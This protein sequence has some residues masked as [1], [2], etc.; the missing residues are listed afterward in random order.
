MHS[1]HCAVHMFDVDWKVARD[2]T[3]NVFPQKF[4]F[5]LHFGKM[6]PICQSKATV[7]NGWYS[8][9]LQGS[10][11]LWLLTLTM[12]CTFTAPHPPHSPASVLDWH[13]TRRAK[14]K[15]SRDDGQHSWSAFLV[16]TH[17]MTGMHPLF[18][19]QFSPSSMTSIVDYM[20]QNC[21]NKK[22]CSC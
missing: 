8:Y 5:F 4:Y 13:L 2:K 11:V 15:H 20:L 3:S 21:G 17:L 7:L 12:T 10:L 19:W 18:L 16:K 9:P 14:S 6:S 1:V 22:C